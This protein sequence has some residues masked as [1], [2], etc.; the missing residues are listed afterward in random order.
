LIIDYGYKIDVASVHTCS[1]S[2]TL[3]SSF[4]SHSKQNAPN[5]NS[6][7]HPPQRELLDL[8]H[9]KIYILQTAVYMQN[10]MVMTF[11]SG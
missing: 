6:S 3:T 9:M 5:Y 8:Q 2:N 10:N 7:H 1:L 11:V 4:P